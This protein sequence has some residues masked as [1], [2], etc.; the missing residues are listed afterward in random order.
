LRVLVVPDKFKGTLSAT[1]AAQ[2]IAQGWRRAR[3][4][5]HLKLIPMSD[6]G[7]GFGEVMGRFSGAQIQKAKTVDAAHRPCVAEWWW[8]DKTKT[9]VIE[10]A[11]VIGLAMLPPKRFHPFELDTFGLGAIFN[12]AARKGARECLVGIGGSA[13]NDAGFGMARAMGWRFIDKANRKLT[14]W[15]QLPELKM[16]HLPSEERIFEKVRVAVDVR[17]PLVGRLGATR[18]YGPQ[19]GLLPADFAMAENCLT[20]L[21]NVWKK[22]FQHDLKQTPG[23]GAA[24]G[25]GFGL[26]AFLGARLEPG[27][28]LF[29][30]HSG[31][32]QLIQSCDLVLT[33]EGAIDESTLMGKGV[34]QLASACRKWGV[35]CIALAGVAL[36]SAR[37]KRTFAQIHALNDI[38][39]LE[40]AKVRAK[41][42]LAE[43]TMRVARN[44][45][46]IVNR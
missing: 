42:L 44:L 46:A 23:A 29:A 39:D 18:V 30:R 7:E 34:G 3:P 2:A 13:T 27:F 24:G 31:L 9:A 36:P 26:M 45:P 1:V 32:E 37:V 16:I 38:A 10:T 35:P 22:Q 21:A 20:R 15:P 14:T 6:G 19:K 8:Q 4:Q 5:D 25:L 43:L 12:A 41:S 11:R 28:H 40:Q 17:N 33:A